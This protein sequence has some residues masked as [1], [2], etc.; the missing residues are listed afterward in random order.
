MSRRAGT[1]P[2]GLPQDHAGPAHACILNRMGALRTGAVSLLQP[3]PDARVAWI[4]GFVNEIKA[5][6]GR[7]AVIYTATTWWDSRTGDN[8][9]FSASPLFIANYYGS[10]TPLPAGWDTWTLRQHADSGSL[11]GDQDVFNGSISGL[12]ALAGAR[13]GLSVTEAGMHLVA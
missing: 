3:H 7:D 12:A 8:T 9:T 5:C 6:T 1:R 2:S 13:H 10:P 4:R 11:P